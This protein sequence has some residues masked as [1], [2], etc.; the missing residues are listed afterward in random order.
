MNDFATIIGSLVLL[1]MLVFI[2]PLIGAVCGAFAGFVVGWVFP[3]TF[4]QFFATVGLG[5]FAPW[6]IGLSLGF[7]GGFFKTVVRKV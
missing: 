6:Q 2:A 5:A 3:V 4:A 7:V 1:A